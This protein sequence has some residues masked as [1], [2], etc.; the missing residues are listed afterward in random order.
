[1]KHLYKIL[2][3]EEW[4]ASKDRLQN[5]SS[6]DDFIHLSL[7][8]QLERILLKFFPEKD[9]IIIKLDA[10]KLKGKLIYES[11]P[12]GTTKYYHLYEGHIP[13]DAVVETIDYPSI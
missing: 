12:G 10:E 2:T 1:M 11:N 3:N 6:D 4:Q 8:S 9:C 13:M 7:E 5:S